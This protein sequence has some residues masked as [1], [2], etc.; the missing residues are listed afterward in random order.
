MTTTMTPPR[1]VRYLSGNGCGT[2]HGWPHRL[3]EKTPTGVM[4]ELAQELTVSQKRLGALPLAS[5]REK[6]QVAAV[7][8]LLGLPALQTDFPFWTQVDPE[9]AGILCG[10]HLLTVEDLEPLVQTS[11][12]GLD[13]LYCYLESWRQIVGCYWAAQIVHHLIPIIR[14]NN[15]L[16]LPEY[17][18]SR[19]PLASHDSEPIMRIL[20]LHGLLDDELAALRELADAAG[21]GSAQC[22]FE[23]AKAFQSWLAQTNIRILQICGLEAKVIVNLVNVV[24]SRGLERLRMNCQLTW[25]EAQRNFRLSCWIKT[26]APTGLPNGGIELPFEVMRRF[27][28]DSIVTIQQHIVRLAIRDSWRKAQDLLHRALSDYT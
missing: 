7:L 9:R 12:F 11:N 22:E 21:F 16:A 5:F 25:D 13:T 20:D 23:C 1:L 18:G 17:V 8:L 27:F 26:H 15:R 24:G 10:N 14:S 2:I 28:R 19:T 6:Q 3:M 4:E